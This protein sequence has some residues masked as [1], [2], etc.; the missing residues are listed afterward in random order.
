MIGTM[1][2]PNGPL[3]MMIVAMIM[4]IPCMPDDGV[5]GLRCRRTASPGR[6][7][8]VRMSIARV[9]PTAKSTIV[10]HEVL[11][12]DHLVVGRELAGTA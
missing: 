9:P 11:H 12:A 1:K 10:V 2:F 5:V 4:M 7:R 6:M 3:I 8:L